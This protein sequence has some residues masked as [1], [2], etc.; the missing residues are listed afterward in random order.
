MTKK[1]PTPRVKVIERNKIFNENFEEIK[2]SIDL[3]IER[4][5]GLT[6]ADISF[7]ANTETD[8][9]GETPF[10]EWSFERPE[11][12]QE[13]EKRCADIEQRK[14]I[15][16]LEAKSKKEKKEKADRATYERLKKKYEN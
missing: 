12:D 11:T 9:Y 2:D 6:Y 13:Y 5:P 1:R 4:N 7:D 10:I 16:E 15:R 14:L 8:W 3:A